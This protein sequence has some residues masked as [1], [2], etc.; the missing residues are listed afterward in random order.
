MMYRGCL[1][2]WM[3][4]L[5]AVVVVPVQAQATG[6]WVIDTQADWLSGTVY[7]TEALTSPGSI[8]VRQ[9]VNSDFSYGGNPFDPMGWP[10]L[11]ETNNG[12]YNRT[13]TPGNLRLYS[14]ASY[15]EWWDTTDTVVKVFQP[16]GGEFT[17]ST[18]VDQ[19]GVAFHDYCAA[20][21]FVR[22]DSLNWF[23]F[24][25]AQRGAGAYYEARVTTNGSSATVTELPGFNYGWFRIWVDGRT[26]RC[27]YSST[28]PGIWT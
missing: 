17:M 10:W 9:N 15:S 1:S 19:S 2:R 18:S 26:F 5:L 22:Q 12:Y 14:G 27:F 25:V 13:V 11:V 24:G 3:A 8:K 28:A 16:A 21:L 4:A 20:Q 23:A 7:N 6:S